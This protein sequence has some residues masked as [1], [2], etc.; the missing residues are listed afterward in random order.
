MLHRKNLK[1]KHIYMCLKGNKHK[2]AITLQYV[3]ISAQLLIATLFSIPCFWHIKNMATEGKRK[4]MKATKQ[5][6][7][8]TFL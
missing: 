5:L 3:T 4:I 8:H 2:A 7:Q 1:P 6:K